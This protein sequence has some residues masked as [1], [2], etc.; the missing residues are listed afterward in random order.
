MAVRSHNTN[1]FIQVR[2]QITVI[3]V[4]NHSLIIVSLQDTN[5]HT[6]EKPYRCDICGKSFSE[7]CTLTAHKRIH[8]GEK[9]YHCNICSKSFTPNSYLTKHKHIHTGVK[10]KW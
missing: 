1:V 6:G 7:N 9:P 5:I 10:G 3:S 4:V 8:T 2:S